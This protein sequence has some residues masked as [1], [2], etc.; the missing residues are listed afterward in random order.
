[1]KKLILL[2]TLGSLIFSGASFAQDSEAPTRDGAV[3][4]D[5]GF[6]VPRAVRGNEE[7][8]EA[9]AT[10][11]ASQVELR[12]SISEVRQR[13]AAA[14]EE[15]KE[16]IK[17]ELRELMKAHRK[18]QLDFRKNVRSIVREL[19]KERAEATTEG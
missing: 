12:S 5:G 18:A 7:V 8:Q 6:H 15:G 9:M 4:R 19:R 16:E 13:L 3:K 10:Y 14:G 2:I 1:M 11:R 17:T